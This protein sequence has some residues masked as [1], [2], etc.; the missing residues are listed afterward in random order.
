MQVM[1]PVLDTSGQPR[2]TSQETPSSPRS[3]HKRKR[4]DVGDSEARASNEKKRSRVKR[5]WPENHKKSQVQNREEV[6]SV[7]KVERGKDHHHAV[8]SKA[9]KP[10][11]TSETKV[12][13]RER[14]KARREQ[15]SRSCNPEGEANKPNGTSQSAGEDADSKGAEDLRSTARKKKH[16]ENWVRLDAGST[17]KLSEPIGGR[18]VESEPL[19]SADEKYEPICRNALIRLLNRYHRYLILGKESHIE[20]YSSSTSSLV[21]SLAI[22]YRSPISAYSLSTANPNILFVSTF[23]G[24][25]YKWDWNEGKKLAR[26]DVSSQITGLA[27]AA[28]PNADE[29]TVYTIDKSDK[30]GK[31]MVTA[32]KLVAG[33]QESGSELSTLCKSQE[34]ITG[35]KVLEGG[36]TLVATSGKRLMIGL[37]NFLHQTPLA[38]ITYTWREITLPEYITCFDAQLPV[39]S[40]QLHS[41][42]SEKLK[43]RNVVSNPLVNIV[44]GN[45]KGELYVYKDLLDM[46]SQRERP[47]K[48]GKAA[49]LAAS[50]QHWHREAVSTVKWSRDGKH[51]ALSSITLTYI[52]S[53]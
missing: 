43:N 11:P 44:V 16:R 21:R 15:E 17:W 38:S 31:W 41:A 30:R 52:V 2:L 39:T 48:V 8:W 50:L 42:G 51:P 26:W 49:G 12:A 9:T 3:Q 33:N 6:K 14:R 18:F 27:T 20:V 36:R 34:P 47:D 32:H 45:T 23:A 37:R 1:S 28:M 10:S 24:T 5:S 7:S 40:T 35:L 46:L 4:E 25:I 22:G 29:D 53:R 19:F 13:K